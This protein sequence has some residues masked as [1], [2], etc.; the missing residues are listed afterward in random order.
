ML[1]AYEGVDYQ[2]LIKPDRVHGSLYYDP[3]IY[4]EELEKIWYREW[5][6]IGH[7]SEVPEPGDYRTGHIGEQPI[8][9]TRDRQNAVR[10]YMNRCR[11]RANIV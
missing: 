11:H 8:I 3:K 1:K 9:L 5:V 10:V 2:S 7:D 4:A 6:F